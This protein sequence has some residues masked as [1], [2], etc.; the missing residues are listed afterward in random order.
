MSRGSLTSLTTLRSLPLYLRLLLILRRTKRL[1]SRVVLLL[2]RH[3]ILIILEKSI[4]V[5]FVKFH[6]GQIFLEISRLKR[7]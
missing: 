7:I 6:L 3:I 5:N 2:L 1:L 4:I